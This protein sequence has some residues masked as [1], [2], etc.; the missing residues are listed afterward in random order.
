MTWMRKWSSH[1][2]MTP[3]LCRPRF[4]VSMLGPWGGCLLPWERRGFGATAGGL[5]S[6]KARPAGPRPAQI[7]AALEPAHNGQGYGFL[8]LW[9]NGLICPNT[10]VVDGPLAPLSLA[11]DQAARLP[12]RHAVDL[13]HLREAHAG[14]PHIIHSR[15]ER[16]R[17]LD[18][19]A[20]HPAPLLAE[21][22]GLPHSSGAILPV[23]IIHAT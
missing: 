22:V 3:A 17:R 8:Y 21:L 4:S 23:R 1:S 14:L 13:G 5:T 19:A 20:V 7:L 9:L 6:G 11:P 2:I 18:C 15:R 12:A 16:V 10:G